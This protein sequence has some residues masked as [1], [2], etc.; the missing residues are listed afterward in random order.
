MTNIIPTGD[1]IFVE[2]IEEE[3]T[4]SGII[5]PDTASKEKPQ[6]G[7]VI[8]VGPGK[9][10]DDNKRIGMEVKDG[11]VVL[12]AKYGPSEIKVDGKNL[13][14]LNETDVLAILK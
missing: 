2:S 12:F 10:G 3:V 9:V 6:K 1:H 5:I 14:V 7:K 4:A 8:A 13:L 11:D